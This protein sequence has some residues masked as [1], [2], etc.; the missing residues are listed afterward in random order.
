MQSDRAT[1]FV[2]DWHVFQNDVKIAA[3]NVL[4]IFTMTDPTK[5]VEKLRLHLLAHLW[6]DI[7]QFGPL[8]GVST[9]AFECFNAIFW[10]CSIY[11]NHLASSHDISRQLAGQESLK[12]QITGG[13]W[14]LDPR[15]IDWK[16][17]GPLVRDFIHLQP[18]LQVLLGWH[19]PK[20]LVKDQSFLYFIFIHI[21]KLIPTC[22]CS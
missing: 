6:E 13:W 5:M 17:A 16:Q 7:I 2:S 1:A 14:Q 18:M 4:D 10:F 11:S 9:K 21:V 20:P 15:K 22:R 19:S 8:V 12:H 3:A